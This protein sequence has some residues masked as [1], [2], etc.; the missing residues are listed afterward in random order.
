LPLRRT[1]PRSSAGWPSRP[2]FSWPARALLEA[3]E[4]TSG[5][6]AWLRIRLPEH[7]WERAQIH[8][9]ASAPGL[10]LYLENLP[11]YLYGGLHAGGPAARGHTWH[12]VP[13]PPDSAG[14]TLYLRF[15]HPRLYS[16]AYEDPLLGPA[17][18]T[19]EAFDRA[20]KTALRREAPEFV[21]GM[22]LTV[23]GYTAM[24]GFF[25]LLRRWK[26]R[27]WGH[28]AFRDFHQPLRRP[29]AERNGADRIL[30]RYLAAY[31]ALPERLHRLPHPHTGHW[32]F[33]VHPGARMEILGATSLAGSPSVRSGGDSARPRARYSSFHAGGH[34]VLVALGQ[35]ILLAHVLRPGLKLAREQRVLRAGYLIFAGFVLNENLVQL[36]LLPWSFT[37]E[38][39]GFWIF[40]SCLA[41]VVS[42]RLISTRQRLAAMEQELE[43]ARRI[44]TSILPRRTPRLE[45]MDIAVRYVPMA[46]VAGDFCEF[47]AVDEK[48][49]GMLVADVSGHG[50]PAALIASMVKVAFSAQ[51]PVAARP[52]AVLSGMNRLFCGK[53]ESQFVTAAYL[54]ADL[55]TGQARYASAGH[56]P[57][58]WWR[59][60]E[61]K[62][63]QVRS[64]GMMLGHFP[65]ATYESVEL[66]FGPGDRFVLYT[67]GVVEATNLKGE[68]FGMERF[69]EAIAGRSHLGA[70]SLAG[71]LLAHLAQWAGKDP[72][73]DGF[74][75]DLTLLVASVGG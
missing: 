27:E 29:P 67:D 58:L 44:Q 42:H 22:L 18:A 75:D 73:R 48:R 53:L 74:A 25:A 39:V 3:R 49:L 41:D 56:P 64:N 66:A 13:L 51:A 36:G 6:D 14:K 54:Y 46:A 65:E 12:V 55:A 62:A 4:I 59:S 26:S 7:P 2:A 24:V 40:I 52:D 37:A 30:V 63:R 28:A 43:T 34:N 23:I 61:K 45:G 60:E 19:A 17:E 33:R 1:K 31:L 47:L 5:E 38:W 71:E 16:V 9:Y 8:L 68:F 72:E 10:A 69:T 57:L 32:P 70:E 11:I 21:F 50:V 35:V 15:Q 20:I